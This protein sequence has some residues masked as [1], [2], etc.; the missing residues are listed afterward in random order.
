MEKLI[1]ITLIVVVSDSQSF[2]MHILSNRMPFEEA[3][4]V[5]TTCDQ[6]KKQ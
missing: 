3:V 1:K 4:S 6:C 2:E 5:L